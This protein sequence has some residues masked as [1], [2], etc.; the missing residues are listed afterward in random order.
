MINNTR[1]G[2]STRAGTTEQQLGVG[3]GVVVMVVVVVVVVV[4]TPVQ[5]LFKSAKLLPFI[6][7]KIGLID[8]GNRN[9]SLHNFVDVQPAKKVV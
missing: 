7:C 3:G 1:G 2:Q 9:F 5:L 6:E 8:Q 4:M